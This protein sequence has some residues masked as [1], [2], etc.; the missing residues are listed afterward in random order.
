VYKYYLENQFLVLNVVIFAKAVEK[1]GVSRYSFKYFM[2][3]FE[4]KLKQ[5]QK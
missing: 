2:R 5:A 1:I 3:F 4:E